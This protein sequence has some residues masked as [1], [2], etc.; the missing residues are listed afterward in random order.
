LSGSSKSKPKL[1]AFVFKSL[2]R[3]ILPKA[4]R[5]F[6]E[7]KN[8]QR[9][10]LLEIAAHL[11][12][13]DFSAAEHGLRDLPSDV[14]TAAE[15]RLILTFWLRVWNH[16]FAGAPERTD[17]IGA[18]FRVLE[19]ALASGDVWP[20]FKMAD[21]AEAVLG[22]AEVA[23]TLAVAIWDHLPGSNFGLQ[24]QAIS[25]CFAGGDPAIL[26]AIFSHLLKSDAE[27]VPD[28]WQYQ[29]LARRWSEA[30]GAPV[31]VRAQSLLHNTGRA[32]LNRLFDIYLLILRQSDIGQA[33][34]LARELTHET[35]RHR[36]SGYLVGASQTSALIGEAVRL[37]D[38]LAP[39][40][41]EDE[42]HLMQARLA[43][44]QGEWPKVLEHTCGI[45]DHPE[46]RNTAVCLRAIALAYL[47]DHENARAAIDHV[48]YNRHA[49]W[50]LRG[51]AALIGMT[52]RILRDGGTPV[53]RVASPELATGAGR[54]LAQSL[55]VGPQLRWIEQLSMKSYLLNGWRYKLFVYDEPAG[56][57]EGVELCDAA[58]IL[59]RSAIFQEGDGSGAHKGSLGAF[60]DLFRYALLARLGGLWTDTDVVNLRAF[61]PEGQ[62]LIASEWTDAGLIGPN[63][64]MMAAPA[65]DPLQRTALETAQEL[66]AS[67]EMHFA[68][69]GPE[70]LAELLGDGGAQGYQVLPPHF[71][72]PIGW[73]ETGRL[74]Q[75]FETTR[76]IEVLQK[77]HNLHVYTETWR[78]IGLGLTRPPEGG[79]FLP[80]L[81]E[82]L[83]NAEGMAP[84]RVME[85]I[86]A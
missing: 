84:R 86:S 25:R 68:R 4:F 43:V 32:D 13:R 61:D 3:N 15:R 65:N 70:L 44:A 54:P 81:Y 27:F 75:P 48:R 76:R 56:V 73:M 8:V 74:L 51:R 10:P 34:S 57:P 1:G 39:L 20:A 12:A 55:W 14:R 82:R 47:G 38:A 69:I 83:M 33:F 52:D 26:D 60:S 17:A 63:G 50:F 24:Y 42:R 45:L 2:L 67:G 30:G 72:N 49:P 37:H 16:R 78:L 7:A 53:D 62:R 21:D 41:A 40:D 46:Q 64:A 58:A 19:R 35:Q 6:L 85:L 28:F 11:D 23:Q 5:G 31:E 9:P 22:A 29:S 18:W 59:P 79:G 71:L 80:T 77:A 36:L 66:L